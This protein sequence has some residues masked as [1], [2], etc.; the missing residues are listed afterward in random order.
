MQR[1]SYRTEPAVDGESAFLRE[2]RHF[3]HCI[4]AGVPNR[5]PRTADRDDVSQIIDIVTR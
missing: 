2:L 1:R 4:V 5:T 3:H